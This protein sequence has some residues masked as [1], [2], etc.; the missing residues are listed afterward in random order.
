MGSKTQPKNNPE[1]GLLAYLANLTFI[2]FDG[3]NVLNSKTLKM[4][5]RKFK[6]LYLGTYFAICCA[7][8]LFFIFLNH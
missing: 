3:I 2:F 8:M 4:I 6:K 5:L 1:I 7:K